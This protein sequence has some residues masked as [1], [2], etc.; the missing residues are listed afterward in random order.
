MKP[1]KHRDLI[2]LWSNGAEIEFRVDDTVGWKT[3]HN[4]L[5]LDTGEYRVKAR[6]HEDTIKAWA[7]GATVEYRINNRCSWQTVP[8]PLWLANGQYR[9]KSIVKP[10]IPNVYTSFVHW[11][12]TLVTI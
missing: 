1:R 5:W 2:R 7:D 12:N 9:V 11:I 8:T 4:P 6:K 10:S 3:V